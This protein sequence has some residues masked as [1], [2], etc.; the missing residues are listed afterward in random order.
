MCRARFETPDAIRRAIETFVKSMDA[1]K[2]NKEEKR[3]IFSMPEGELALAAECLL[4][5]VPT[6]SDFLP[7][8]YEYFG[9]EA[10]FM[11]MSGP[12][13]RI[14]SLSTLSWI[15]VE[16][17]AKEKEE[18]RLVTACFAKGYHERPLLETF[19]HLVTTATGALE[20]RENEREEWQQVEPFGLQDFLLA[21]ARIGT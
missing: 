10:F 15:E 12:A 11:G 7:N 21:M 2:R 14:S 17:E 9:R 3:K 18:R 8:V 16:K 1:P 20:R 19:L 6:A 5:D 13:L 4:C